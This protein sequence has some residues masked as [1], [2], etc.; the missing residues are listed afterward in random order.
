[1]RWAV[2][3]ASLSVAIA[4][5][6][7]QEVAFGGIELAS[8]SV[9]GL[10]FVFQPGTEAAGQGAPRADRM[11]RLQYAERNASFISMKDGCKLNER[12]MNLLV[13][14]TQEVVQELRD[15]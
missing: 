6:G 2:A 8:S 4:A 9:K 3:L 11:Q 13:K 5:A 14:D 15:G 10:T 12:G 7:A 1:M